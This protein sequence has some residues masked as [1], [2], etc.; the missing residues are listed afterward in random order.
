MEKFNATERELDAV[1]AQW[2]EISKIWAKDKSALQESHR[3]AKDATGLLSNETK[4]KPPEEWQQKF[5]TLGSTD[6][7]VLGAF[8]DECDSDLRHLKRIP[9]QT[10]ADIEALKEKLGAAR[11]EKDALERTIANKRHEAKKLK[12]KWM[13]GVQELVENVNDKFGNMMA[14]LGY[15]GEISLSQGKDD[16][17]FSSYGIKIKVVFIKLFAINTIILLQVRFRQGQDLQDLSKGTQSGGEKSV[18]TAVYMM[19]LQEMTQV[20]FRCVDEINQG[21]T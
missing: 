7:A 1:K 10:I 18:S 9:E 8:L 3:I 5:D 2:D 20:P 19:A 14:T 16:I 21:G 15:N 6:E 4:Y 11:E 17:D 12:L 13:N